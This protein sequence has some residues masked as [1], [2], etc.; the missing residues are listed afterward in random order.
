MTT[1]ANYYSSYDLKRKRRR[2]E[3][4]RAPK[5]CPYCRQRHKTTPINQHFSEYSNAKA[6]YHC[7]DTAC[8]SAAYRQ[9]KAD[10]LQAAR[11]DADARINNYATQLLPEQAAAVRT[12]RDVLMCHVQADY[13]HG[14]EQALAIIQ[15]IEARACKHDRIAVLLDNASAAKRRADKAEAY[16]EELKDIYERRIAE[17]RAELDLYQNLENAVH[18]IASRQLVIQPDPLML[19]QPAM[20]EPEDED[21]TRVLATLAQAGIMPIDQALAAE[22]QEG[23]NAAALH[24]EEKPGLDDDY[25][26]YEYE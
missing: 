21:R 5:E 10:R 4:E 12:M 8:R 15:T 2:E 11:E 13:Q 1:Y 3:W 20:P 26:A 18:N 17:L 16:N 23:N 9:R 14:H 22:Q 19:R 7:G 6:R 25:D 24:D